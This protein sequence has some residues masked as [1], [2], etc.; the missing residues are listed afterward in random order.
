MLHSS[1]C[2]FLIQAIPCFDLHFLFAADHQEAGNGLTLG[3]VLEIEL[4]V[5]LG[6]WLGILIELYILGYIRL[7][8][9][10]FVHFL[11]QV[12]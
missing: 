11:A 5:E 7:E 6:I 9:G 1:S 10:G 3:F 12:S 4:K 8:V 2:N